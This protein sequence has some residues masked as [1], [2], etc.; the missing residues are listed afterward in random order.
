MKQEVKQDRGKQIVI[1]GSQPMV[2]MLDRYARAWNVSRQQWV[3]E[4]LR[5]LMTAR[6]PELIERE[7]DNERWGMQ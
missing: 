3:T 6:M 7:A 2:D 5:D 1:Y 4:Q